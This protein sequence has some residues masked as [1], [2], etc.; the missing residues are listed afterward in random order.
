MILFVIMIIMILDDFVC[1]YELNGFARIR[2][3]ETCATKMLVA[4]SSSLLCAYVHFESSQV[5]VQSAIFQHEP[6]SKFCSCTRSGSSPAC[7]NKCFAQL[8]ACQVWQ[9]AQFR[10]LVCKPEQASL[11][12]STATHEQNGKRCR[13]TGIGHPSCTYPQG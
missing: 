6:S 3:A 11:R 2:T 8:C 13:S 9:G 12:L 4:R 10:L 5:P 1:Y 7:L